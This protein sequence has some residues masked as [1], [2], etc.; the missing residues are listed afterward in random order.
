MGLR[1]NLKWDFPIHSHSLPTSP[2]K[3]PASPESRCQREPLKAYTSSYVAPQTLDNEFSQVKDMQIN[4]RSYNDLQSIIEDNLN[5]VGD[6]ISSSQASLQASKPAQFNLLMENLNILEETLADSNVLRLERDILQQL[7]RLGALKLF[8]TCLTSNVLDSFDAPTEDI[9]STKSSTKDRVFVRS[10]KKEKR[11]SRRERVLENGK[12]I[13]NVSLTTKTKEEASQQP[14]ISSAKRA[15]QSRSRRLMLAKQQ[16]EMAR[17]VKVMTEL[18]RIRAAL[19]EGTGQIASLSCWAEAAGIDQKLLQQQLHYGWK[20]RDEILRSTR[21]LVM[22]LSRYYRRPGVAIEE[23]LQAGNLG[24][25]EGAKRFD[26]NRGCQFSTY[27]QF[28]IRRSM[29]TTVA[30]STRDVNI[31]AKLSQTIYKIRKAENAL[32]DGHRY[33]NDAEISKFTGLSLSRIEWARRSLIVGDNHNLSILDIAPDSSEEIAMKEH[34]KED[35]HVLLNSLNPKESRILFLR[36]GLDNHRPRSLGE[37]GKLCNVSKEW[38][39]KVERKAMAKL[40]GEEMAQNLRH[41]LAYIKGS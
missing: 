29:S 26:P 7:D 23:L 2:F 41:Y 28:W 25:L 36:F 13:S 3:L 4:K 20:C 30:Q 19:E 6:D 33:P 14:S 35:I 10:L 11:K 12:K 31:P 24:V 22:Y 38:I 37:T 34:M 1:L 18:E 5:L 9:E 15:S 27:V 32:K 16:I 39:R 40:R 8:D 21:P 17:G